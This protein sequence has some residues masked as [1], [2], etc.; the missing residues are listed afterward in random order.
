MMMAMMPANTDG[1][2]VKYWELSEAFYMI[3]YYDHL[4]FTN[5]ETQATERLKHLVTQLGSS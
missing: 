1:T 3:V 5:E 2:H 4:H